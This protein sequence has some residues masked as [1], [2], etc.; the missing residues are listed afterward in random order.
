[1]L[2][3]NST[4]AATLAQ[5]AAYMGKSTPIH[6]EST[7]N[8]K[9]GVIPN[10]HVGEGNRQTL[11][12]FCIGNG[13]AST[14]VGVGNAKKLSTSRHRRRDMALFNHIPF[15]ARPL[16]ND[17]TEAQRANYRLRKVIDLNGVWTA[18]Y[19]LKRL[20]P[21]DAP[22]TMEYRRISDDGEVTVSP[23]EFDPGDLNPTPTDVD[24]NELSCASGS[25]LV[26]YGVTTIELLGFDISE[27]INACML[28]YG[29]ADY[30][31]IS[32]IGLCTSFDSVVEGEFTSD[33]LA[34]DYTEAA[35]VQL[36]NHLTSDVYKLTEST[37]DIIINVK[38][39]ADVY[40]VD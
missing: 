36:A 35:Y 2:K 12:T 29:D 27:I 32:E 1:M 40:S 22:P 16:D 15:S 39:G 10:H 33:L 5:I 8:E 24:E 18:L 7:L 26:T 9:F 21:N 3:N 37:E 13:A 14:V 17:L 25:S 20:T 4:P 38:I 23:Y 31:N 30:A 28:L 34:Q 6:P 11:N 19:Y